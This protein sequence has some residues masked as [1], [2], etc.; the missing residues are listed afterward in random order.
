[1]IV[2]DT[3]VWLWWMIRDPRLPARVRRR[4]D[5]TEVGVASM[6]CYEVVL[7][8]RRRRIALD[9]DVRSWIELAL[10]RDGVRPLHLDAAVATEAALLDPLGFPPDPADRIIYATARAHG[11]VLATK[12]ERI[13]AHDPERTLW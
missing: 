9:R 7:L 8:E 11:A 12:D 10:A 6:S 2:L 5:A 3:H 13:R 1:V 4:I